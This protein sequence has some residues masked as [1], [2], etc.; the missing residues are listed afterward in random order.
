M[1]KLNSNIISLDTA[2][3]EI[4]Q[5]CEKPKEGNSRS[6][7]FFFAGSGISY[8]SIPLAST[9][10]KK[11]EEIA[12]SLGRMEGTESN[13]PAE[14]YS[15]WFSSAFPH[16]I[17]R[18]QYLRDL[19]NGAS[20]T[21]ANLR[22]ADLLSQG[23]I[24]SIAVTPNFDDLLSRSLTM[25]GK[26]Y[27]VCDDPRTVERIDPEKPDIQLIHVHGS[28]W[29][30]D[31]R[32]TDREIREGAQPLAETTLTMAAMLDKILTYRSPIVIGYSGW[33][34]DV[35][36]TALKRRLLTPLPFNLYWFC[37]RR[38]QINEL[39][40][41]LKNHADVYFVVPPTKLVEDGTEDNIDKD[42]VQSSSINTRSE[43][44]LSAV[45]VLDALIR[46][47]GM[48]T[49]E[50]TKDPLSFFANQLRRN[51][52][53]ENAEDGRDVY[54]F[55]NVIERVERAK[56]REEQE[57]EVIKKT[58]AQLEAVREALR[59]AE[60]E[61]AYNLANQINI[62]DAMFR[63]DQLR[64]LI[65]LIDSAARSMPDTSPLKPKACDLVIDCYNVLAKKSPTQSMPELTLVNTSNVKGCAFYANKNYEEAISSFD[66]AISQFA[67][68]SNSAIQEQLGTICNNKGLALRS[69]EKN[70]EAIAVHD[71]VI[72][73]LGKSDSNGA[74]N[75]SIVAFAFK[76]V[77]LS[78]LKSYKKA[79]EAF[80]LSDEYIPKAKELTA[81]TKTSLE[82]TSTTRVAATTAAAAAVVVED[83]VQI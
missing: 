8:P 39:P 80:E 69:L 82:G 57:E 61:D 64:D 18:Q 83:K 12:H 42:L 47:T 62:K 54:S 71:F 25:F 29:F 38:T 23:T 27:V 19:M 9:I 4:K 79:V 81:Y 59:R 48:Q 28:Y 43:P 60:Y 37:Y 36:M 21:H 75:T 73:L 6:P 40:D 51:L 49:P 31:C 3:S 35:F 77:S 46:Q 53:P 13:D 11:C 33:E 7:F 41:F 78:S 72:N 15:H 5:A 52:P 67:S 76:G 30:Y 50:L 2:V 24:S 16:R 65:S 66:Y 63:E 34:S 22:L 68:S 56:L 17:L 32:N 58:E 20:I 70:E 45:T 55:R 14:I 26:Q 74:I 1:I 10:Q 44:T